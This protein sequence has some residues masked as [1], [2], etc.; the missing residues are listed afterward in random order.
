ML[1]GVIIAWGVAV[2]VMTSMQG[3]EGAAE[4]V[5]VT[6]WRTEVRIIGAGAIGIAAI[7]TLLKLIG[8]L[9]SGIASA[10]AAQ[11]KRNS[12]ETLAITEQD[13][14]IGIVGILSLTVLGAIAVLL[15][16]FT[17]GSPL[18]AQASALVAGG[19]LYV[20]IIGFIVAE[21]ISNCF[22]HA[23]SDGPGRVHV[24]VSGGDGGAIEIEVSD[25]GPGFRMADAEHKG[26]VGLHIARSLARQGDVALTQTG[27]LGAR[28][29]LRLPGPANRAT[30]AR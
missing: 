18:A 10:F 2:P 9:V 24:A 8:P 22:C 28:W 7:W 27:G 17:Q 29:S 13:I 30:D 11:S 4:D 25:S 16:S 12:K 19:L 5:A 26:S 23:F 1:L 21:L 14:P 20:V 3:L 6:L 15:W